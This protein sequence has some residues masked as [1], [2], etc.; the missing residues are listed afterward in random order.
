M[1][2]SCNRAG[3]S[4]PGNRVSYPYVRLDG[5]EYPVYDEPI[6]QFI[7]AQ[8]PKDG[9][10]YQIFRALKIIYLQCLKVHGRKQMIDCMMLKGIQF[11]GPSKDDILI[12]GSTSISISGPGIPYDPDKL[13]HGAELEPIKEVDIDPGTIPTW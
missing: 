1:S 7:W 13:Y 5:Q 10:R 9:R 2:C 3:F 12:G 4:S 8:N 6:T 11:Y